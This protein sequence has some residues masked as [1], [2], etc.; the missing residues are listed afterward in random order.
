M[1]SLAAI[2]RPAT[3]PTA[4]TLVLLHGF[5]ADEQDLMGLV[6]E[7]NPAW[8]I[9][10]PRAPI[11]LPWGGF[12]WFTVDFL[13]DGRRQY[14]GNQARAAT[15]AVER[16][17]A[18]LK[19]SRPD[20]PLILGGFSQGAMI[21]L[22]VAQRAPERLRALWL[23]S[24]TVVPELTVT[25]FPAFAFPVLVQ[26]GTED[27]VLPVE[28]G[29]ALSAHLTS[30]EVTHDYREYAM[31]HTISAQSL[32]YGLRWIADAISPSD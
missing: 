22:A 18:D 21:A 28:L 3:D 7:V 25:P 20:S 32:E 5:G 13:P 17:L 9:V 8:S 26:H 24:G 6:G 23:M 11:K 2:E 27:E 16:W 4:P 19:G 14:D 15:D 29:R 31:P 30:H 1:T 12:A 10:A